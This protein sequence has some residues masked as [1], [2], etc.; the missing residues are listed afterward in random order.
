MG[1]PVFNLQGQ[2]GMSTDPLKKDMA[3]T[4][5]MLDKLA[6]S[7][8]DKSAGAVDKIRDVAGEAMK[9]FA[10]VGTLYAVK[11]AAAY[12]LSAEQA[13]AY[14]QQTEDT[15]KG[16]AKSPDELIAKLKEA[17]ADTITTGDLINLPPRRPSCW[18]WARMPIPWPIDYI[19]RGKAR[20][21]GKDTLTAYE[22]LTKGIG[23]LSAKQ[24]CGVGG[25][26]GRLQ[27]GVRGLCRASWHDRRQADQGTASA[28]SPL[29]DHRPGARQIHGPAR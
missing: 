20:E 12:A 2:I 4:Q 17:S 6:A 21:F 10:T 23:D 16:L 29:C 15:F 28:G 14:A 1:E 26:A 3:E 8:A 27:A 7:S 11:S 22:D 5:A 18:A 9:A 13:A 25:A 24:P 19:A